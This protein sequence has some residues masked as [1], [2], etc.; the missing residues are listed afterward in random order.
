MLAAK[1]L[2]EKSQP[3][4][5]GAAVPMLVKLLRHGEMSTHVPPS[6]SFKPE[7]RLWLLLLAAA[8]DCSTPLHELLLL[9][10][11]KSMEWRFSCVPC[12]KT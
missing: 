7:P 10:L 8:D 5:D 4:C 12:E 1:L 9:P 6:D 11:D 2:A 3:G